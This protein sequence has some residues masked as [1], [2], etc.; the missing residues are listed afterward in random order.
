MKKHQNPHGFLLGVDVGS[1]KTHA[2]ITDTSGKALGLGIAGCGNYEVVGLEGFKY[3]IQT[4]AQN[5]C[6]QASV[7]YQDVLGMGLGIAGYDWPSQD[8]LMIETIEA[9]GVGCPYHYVNDVELGLIA[10][11]SSGW[12][13]AVDAGAGNNVRGKDQTGKIGRI[14]GNSVYSGEIGGGGEMVWLAQVGV[15]HAWTQRGPKTA[16]TQA[17]ISFAE[18]NSEFELIQ[19]LATRQIHL[20]P[21][22]AE[23]VFQIANEGDQL[24]QEIINT[25]ARELA[26]NVNAVIKQLGFEGHTFDLV[27]IGSIFQSGDIYLNPFSEIVHSFAPN[28]RLVQ[29]STP[30]VAGSILLAAQTAGIHPN[31]IKETLVDSISDLSLTDE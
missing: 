13:I 8:K 23:T 10:G 24:A 17:L 30:P 19:G 6:K 7:H 1:S 14:T 5:A 12:G 29:L 2:L 21:T 18:V 31:T 16:L 3:A 22:L 4:A 26:L 11:S 9:L 15:T 28:A 27:L 20:P 25:S